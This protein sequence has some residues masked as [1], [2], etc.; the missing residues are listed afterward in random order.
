MLTLNGSLFHTTVVAVTKSHLPMAFLG[1]T[2]ETDGLF[3]TVR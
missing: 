2:E 3:S 1:R